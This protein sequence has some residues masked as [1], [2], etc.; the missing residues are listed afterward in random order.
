MKQFASQLEQRQAKLGE[1]DTGPQNPYETIIKSLKAPQ[2]K[3]LSDDPEKD[4]GGEQ[5]KTVF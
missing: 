2:K 5:K 1:Q 3:K 4:M